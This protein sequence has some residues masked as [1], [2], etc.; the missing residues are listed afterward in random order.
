MIIFLKHQILVWEAPWVVFSDYTRGGVAQQKHYQELTPSVSAAGPATDYY[1]KKV[2][3]WA[4]F[5]PGN[6]GN[7]GDSRRFGPSKASF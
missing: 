2:G 1:G 7:C 6:L 5:D 3:K 4:L